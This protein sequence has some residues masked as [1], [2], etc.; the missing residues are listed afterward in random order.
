[1]A[2]RQILEE[3]SYKTVYREGN[4]VI[5]EFAPSHPKSAVFSEAFIHSCVEEAGVPVPKIISVSPHEGGWALTMEYVEGKSIEQLMEE[6]PEKT[7]E[8]LEKLIDIQIETA[9]HQAPRLRNT[10]YKME[11]IISGMR[12]IDAS[13]RYELQQRLHGMKR[14]TRLC[15][16]DFVPSNVILREDGSYVVLDWSHATSGNF[17]ADAAITYMRL[18][19]SKPELAPKYLKLF[20]SKADMPIQYIQKWLPIVAAMQLSKHVESERELLEQWISVVEYQ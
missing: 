19:L 13:T 4:H 8:Y 6:H 18:S 3:K 10:R 17:G 16:G 15:H 11:E 5:K 9:S 2:E 20:C 7:E 14:H 12:E 1:M